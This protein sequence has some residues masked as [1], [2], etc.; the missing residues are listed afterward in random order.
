VLTYL[1][2]GRGF[3]EADVE[4][5]IQDT[6]MTIYMRNWPKVRTLD[7]PEAYWL[8]AAERRC[9]RVLG[10]QASRVVDGD[11]A[12]RLLGV[13]HPLDQFAAADCRE[14]LK[15]L[16][17]KLPRRQ[18]QVLWLR[19]AASFTEA[20]TAGI[21]DITVGS[22]KRHLHDARERVQ[23]LRRKDSATREADQIL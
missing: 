11:P 13:A 15:S 18:R 12:E 1:V 16:L 6:I 19:D 4:D 7:K 21:L 22:V 20:E 8:T 3:P 17:S 23:Q 2:F 9:R 5:I 14:A 10:R